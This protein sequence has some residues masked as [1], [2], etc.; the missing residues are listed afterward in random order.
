SCMVKRQPALDLGG[1]PVGNVSG[2]DLALWIKLAADTPV[3]ISSY[4][5]CL[6]R[7]GPDSLTRQSWHRKATDAS[8]ST[9]MDLL[10]QRKNW[11][12]PRKR[13]AKEYYCRL[14]LAHGLDCLRAEE[15]KEARHFLRLAA[16][17]TLLRNRLWT[18]RALAFVPP[19]V[20]AALFRLSDLRRRR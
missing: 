15:V 18:G 9:L 13:S 1:F 6:Y 4:I 12:D 7:R 5:G 20:R 17:T 8:M 11:P 10:E 19:P 14:A 3:A 16:E 2:E